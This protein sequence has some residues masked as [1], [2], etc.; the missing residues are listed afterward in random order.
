MPLGANS[1]PQRSVLNSVQRLRAILLNLKGVVLQ[2]M[3]NDVVN[4]QTPVVPALSLLS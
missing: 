2:Q 1:P 3:L 4:L